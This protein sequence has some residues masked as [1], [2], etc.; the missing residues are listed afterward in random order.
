MDPSYHL[1]YESVRFILNTRASQAVGRQDREPNTVDAPTSS[2]AQKGKTKIPKNFG[3][4]LFPMKSIKLSYQG[5]E[6]KQCD[7][8]CSFSILLTS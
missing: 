2:R 3:E 5:L 7:D 8:S 6:S 4:P 1:L